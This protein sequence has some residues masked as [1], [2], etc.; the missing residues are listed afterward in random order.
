[1]KMTVALSLIFLMSITLMSQELV[2]QDKSNEFLIESSNLKEL[3][4][5][6]WKEV[7]KYFKSFN[8]KDEVIVRVKY[9]NPDDELE[10]KGKVDNFDI[11]V[12]G[13]ARN[14]KDLTAKMEG[15]IAVLSG[16]F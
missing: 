16:R 12:S 11:S 10:K 7:H 14:I 4:K 13:E 6:K 5:Y 9:V 3:K 15:L 8:K 2:A 1:M